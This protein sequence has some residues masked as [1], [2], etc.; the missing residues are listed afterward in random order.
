MSNNKKNY[1]EVKKQVIDVLKDRKANV[2]KLTRQEILNKFLKDSALYGPVVASENLRAYKENE[3]KPK[4]ISLDQLLE[5]M[6]NKEMDKATREHNRIYE[7]NAISRNNIER[8]TSSWIDGLG[9][10]ALKKKPEVGVEGINSKIVNDKWYYKKYPIRNVDKSNLPVG[11]SFYGK[12]IIG[13]EYAK[14]PNLIPENMILQY[15]DPS[16]N[17]VKLYAPSKSTPARMDIHLNSK[18]EKPSVNFDLML[19]KIR[20]RKFWKKII[21]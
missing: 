3:E 7:P 13:E 20:D 14:K 5:K 16:G 2:A 11:S 21:F 9:K 18:F 17:V 12:K 10:N 4:A 1:I 15:A 6:L 19:K 8:V